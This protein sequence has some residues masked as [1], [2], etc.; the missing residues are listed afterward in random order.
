LLR[1]SP[2]VQTET[3]AHHY[4]QLSGFE[5]EM[6][7]THVVYAI[8][9]YMRGS[10]GRIPCKMFRRKYTDNRLQFSHVYCTHLGKRY[11]LVA[12]S[13]ENFLFRRSYA[14]Y[15]VDLITCAPVN[16]SLID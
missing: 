5:Q 11:I 3:H 13:V 4:K 15:I 12:T 2:T 8:L 7:V 10:D 1:T 6:D 14:R 9:R 16:M